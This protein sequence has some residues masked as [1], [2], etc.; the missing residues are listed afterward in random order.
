[1][2]NEVKKV[3][4]DFLEGAQIEMN[5]SKS[6]DWSAIKKGTRAIMYLCNG[7]PLLV[8]INQAD[9]DEGVSFKLSSES[10]TTYHYDAGAVVSLYVEVLNET[11]S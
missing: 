8:L 9:E 2:S 7:G 4:L 11:K 6:D 3:F 10:S 1:M 5:V